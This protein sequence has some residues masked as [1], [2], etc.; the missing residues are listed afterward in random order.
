MRTLILSVLFTLSSQAFASVHIEPYIG[1][2]NSTVD[3]TQG[4]SSTDDQAGHKAIGAKLGWGILGFDFGI[5]YEMDTHD[6]FSRNNISA[7]AAFQF[8][9]LLRV[10]AELP[11]SSDFKMD[12]LDAK[13]GLKSGSS[14][15]VGFTGLPFVA[16]NLEVENTKYTGDLNGTDYDVQ[17]VSYLLSVSLPLDI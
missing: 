14:L 7:Y 1:F 16:I 10:W 11:I 6:D 9:I 4:G 5:D 8:P 13:L 2:G 12:D 15:G 3:V 17:W